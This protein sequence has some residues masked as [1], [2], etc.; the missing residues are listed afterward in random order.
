MVRIQLNSRTNHIDV[1]KNFPSAD[2]NKKY[3]LTV[4][5][6]TVPTSYT[7]NFVE[8]KLFDIERRARV[9][10]N[11]DQIDVAL[12][13]VDG[14]FIPTNIHSALDLIYEMNKFFEKLILRCIT[15]DTFRF[16]DTEV[17]DAPLGFQYVDGDWL[18]LGATDDGHKLKT[19]LQAILRPDGKIGFKFSPIALELFTI[20]LTAHGKKLFGTMG[21][22]IEGAYIAL[23]DKFKNGNYIDL[24]SSDVL[25]AP[26]V[27]EESVI[28]YGSNS[29]FSHNDY[30]PEVAIMTSLPLQMYVD[31]QNEGAAYKRQLASY[32]FPAETP[33][34]KYAS[35]MHREY[36][37]MHRSVLQFENARRTN[38]T[39]LLTGDQLQNFHI[40]LMLRKYVYSESG[41]RYEMEEKVYDI[42]S[43]LM[44]TLGLN[45]KPLQSK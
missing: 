19:S 11:L 12:V 30:R 31:V 22:D 32:R 44:W 2:Q 10:K 27:G 35:K 40:N 26:P 45:V 42:D 14:G 1:Y 25:S 9:G 37:M 21:G 38:N 28:V 43:D 4:E 29:I 7:N 5:H 20:S 41:R 15:A 33:K 18:A 24:V 17:Y 3:T 6:L 39:F 34:I 23:D 8:Q 16:T 13:P 36:S